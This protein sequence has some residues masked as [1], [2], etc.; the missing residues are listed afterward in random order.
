MSIGVC[1]YA[2]RRPAFTM[3]C[4]KDR[5]WR[6]GDRARR[7]TTLLLLISIVAIT[8]TITTTIIHT[9]IIIIII[10]LLLLIIIVGRGHR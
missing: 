1:L 3:T 2:S 7:I 6:P 10:V 8:I 5:E 4:S 9:S